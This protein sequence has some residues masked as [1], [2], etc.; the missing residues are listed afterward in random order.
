MRWGAAVEVCRGFSGASG[1]A[2]F[3]YCECLHGAFAQSLDVIQE[4]GRG[5]NVWRPWNKIKK[6]RTLELTWIISYRLQKAQTNNDASDLISYAV[7]TNDDLTG[8]YCLVDLISRAHLREADPSQNKDDEA[9]AW[10][11]FFLCDFA[12]LSSTVRTEG[13]S[14][15]AVIRECFYFGMKVS[16]TYSAPDQ[17]WPTKFTQKKETT[18]PDSTWSVPGCRTL[19]LVRPVFSVQFVLHSILREKSYYFIY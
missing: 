16:S 11:T 5:Q 6:S 15:Y 3:L 18:V 9:G 1:I 19:W 7:L 10:P 8:F 4:T 13:V 17:F 14:L 2:P 12:L